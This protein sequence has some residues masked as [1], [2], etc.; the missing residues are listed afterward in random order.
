MNKNMKHFKTYAAFVN[1]S[2]NEGTVNM[3]NL[4]K[5]ISKL[6]DMLQDERMFGDP[7]IKA[8]VKLLKADKLEDAATEF[9]S[10]FADQDG[11]EGKLDW[12]GWQGDVEDTFSEYVNESTLNEGNWKI[13]QVVKYTIPGTSN[14]TKSGKITDFETIEQRDGEMDFAIIDGMQIPFTNLS[15]SILN[16]MRTRK[17]ALPKNRATLTNRILKNDPWRSGKS[18]ADLVD[19]NWD[20]IVK[21]ANEFTEYKEFVAELSERSYVITLTDKLHL[22]PSHFVFSVFKK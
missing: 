16:E 9:L 22:D 10:S 2:L 12:E 4:K 5:D 18:I 6:T 14:K 17:I 1:E 7:D 8:I 20:D 21:I 19:K 3:T 13:G 15:E 11:G